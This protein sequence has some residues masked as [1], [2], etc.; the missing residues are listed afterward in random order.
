MFDKSFY[1]EQSDP[2]WRGVERPSRCPES[3]DRIIPKGQSKKDSPEDGRRPERLITPKDIQ[4]FKDSKAASE[5]IRILERVDAA[6]AMLLPQRDFACQRFHN[7]RH[8]SN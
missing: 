1:L 3:V 7:G 2:T 4:L 5:A 8:Y 6:E